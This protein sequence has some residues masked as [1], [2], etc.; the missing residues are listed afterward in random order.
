MAFVFHAFSACFVQQN[1][2][3][4]FFSQKITNIPHN[5]LANEQLKCSIVNEKIA[6][7]MGND[8]KKSILI[9]LIIPLNF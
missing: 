1:H 4:A 2:F 6:L 5:F 3:T 7:V 9:D 8:E